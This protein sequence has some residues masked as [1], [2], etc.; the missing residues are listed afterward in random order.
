M[1]M[2]EIRDAFEAYA[3]GALAEYELRNALRE[4]VSTQPDAVPRYVAMAAALRRRNLISAELEAVVVSDL[5]ASSEHASAEP[6]TR[7][8]TGNVAEPVASS[9]AMAARSQPRANISANDEPQQP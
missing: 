4:E 9:D 1:G 7:A 2:A 6:K 5:H 3:A 8:T